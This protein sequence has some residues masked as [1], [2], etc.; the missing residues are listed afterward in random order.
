MAGMM[1]GWGGGILPG[2]VPGGQ[3]PQ[4]FNPFDFLQPR[5]KQ[6][7]EGSIEEKMMPLGGQ[8]TQQG[9]QAQP[10]TPPARIINQNEH[11]RSLPWYYKIMAIIDPQGYSQGIKQRN[12]MAMEQE[13]LGLGREEIGMRNQQFAF[14]QE[15]AKIADRQ[16][17]VFKEMDKVAM[18]L[19]LSKT[20]NVGAALRKHHKENLETTANWTP[21]YINDYV[22]G[23]TPLIDP[24]KFQSRVD[25]AGNVSLFGIQQ[26]EKGEH[27]A[28]Y[29][30]GLEKLN[31]YS[32]EGII[33]M[34]DRF[35]TQISDASDK[36]GP[37]SEQVNTLQ[38]LKSELLGKGAGIPPETVDKYSAYLMDKLMKGEL[39]LERGIMIDDNGQ[40]IKLS[41]PQLKLAKALTKNIPQQAAPSQ[42]RFPVYL[43][44][45]VSNFRTKNKREPTSEEMLKA[46]DK[47]G[48]TIMEQFRKGLFGPMLGE[49][50]ITGGEEAEEETPTPTEETQPALTDK[51]KKRLEELKKKRGK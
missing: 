36:F 15:Q 37:D 9:Q 35:S 32:P 31:V 29:V 38:T 27:R 33:D 44:H 30:K 45:W 21:S 11:F 43:R 19:D 40:P 4:Q 1:S 39:D 12:Q 41:P 2:M 24:S 23:F 14:Q 48:E 34:L 25:K 46:I 6:W 50:G 26:D 51:Q 47:Y 16:Q 13:R 28:S 5:P 17:T 18:K 22:S 3:M 20:P 42:S 8:Q 49:M 7:W 10:Q